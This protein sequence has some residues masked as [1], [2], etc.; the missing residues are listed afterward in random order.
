MA[1][2]I[3]PLTQKHGDQSSNTTFTK[4]KNP[5]NDNNKTTK[6]VEGL[7]WDYLKKTECWKEY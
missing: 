4:A 1:Q 3:D 6:H 5:Q 7:S 2:G